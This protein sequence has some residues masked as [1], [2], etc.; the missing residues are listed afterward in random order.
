MSNDWK[1]QK[2]RQKA[3]FTARQNPQYEVKVRRA[4]LGAREFIQESRNSWNF[5]FAKKE[6]RW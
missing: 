2:K 3:I 1:E 6:R 4:E 5:I